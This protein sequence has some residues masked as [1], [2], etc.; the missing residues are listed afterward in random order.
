MRMGVWYSIL[1]EKTV[2]IV[3][4]MNALTNNAIVETVSPQLQL[5]THLSVSDT[6]CL[7]NENKTEVL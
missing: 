6:R 3:R 5:H 1:Y 7:I 2:S 4:S